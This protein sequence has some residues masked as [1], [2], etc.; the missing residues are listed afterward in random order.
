MKKIR[1]TLFTF[2]LQNA[3]H[4]SI[5]RDIFTTKL[6]IRILLLKNSWNFAYIKAAQ[7][8]T[9]FILTRFLTENSK[10]KFWQ[11]FLIS[12]T[13]A[14]YHS[15]KRAKRH[16]RRQAWNSCYSRPLDQ[17]VGLH[18]AF[19]FFVCLLWKERSIK[20]NFKWWFS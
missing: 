2:K 9:T 4:L 14:Q 19:V 16:H 5:W 12:A 18:F 10:F 20:Y 8:R 13:V 3:E 15:G 6:K 1:Q 17:F 11:F 7:C